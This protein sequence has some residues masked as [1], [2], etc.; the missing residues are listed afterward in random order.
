MLCSNLTTEIWEFGIK[1]GVYIS[2]G[3]IL[4]KENIIADLASR[5]FQDSHE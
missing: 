1:R 5:E 4:G 2:A 3:L